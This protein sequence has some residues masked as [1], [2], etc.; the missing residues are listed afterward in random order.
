MDVFRF[1]YCLRKRLYRLGIERGIGGFFFF[2]YGDFRCIYLLF[3]YVVNW[4]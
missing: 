4:R 3:Y 1:V 2:R